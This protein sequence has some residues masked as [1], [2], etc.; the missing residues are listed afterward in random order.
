MRR[1]FIAFVLL[2]FFLVSCY[3]PNA[4]GTRGHTEPTHPEGITIDTAW[5]GDTT[6]YFNP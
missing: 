3:K 4:N 2:V 6:V 1:V 5:L